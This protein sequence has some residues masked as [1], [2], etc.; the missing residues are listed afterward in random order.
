M[1]KRNILFFVLSLIAM[2]MTSL[3]AD[4]QSG[5]VNPDPLPYSL[6][7]PDHAPEGVKRTPPNFD[8][9]P[10]TWV[11]DGYLHFMGTETISSVG[12]VIWDEDENEVLFTTIGIQENMESTINISSLSSGSYSLFLIIDGVVYEA[13]FEL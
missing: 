9:L 4:A 13:D 5:P 8:C 10:E 12:V 3:C 7:D 6:P 1:R 11:S 2:S